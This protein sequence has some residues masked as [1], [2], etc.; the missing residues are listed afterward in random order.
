MA[1]CTGSGDNFINREKNRP[2]GM[3][4]A[5]FVHEL[6]KDAEQFLAQIRGE[7]FEKVR[8]YKTGTWKIQSVE[9][10]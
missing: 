1:K 8:Q 5:A 2:S 10:L 3:P 7:L 4:R 9:L 6:Y